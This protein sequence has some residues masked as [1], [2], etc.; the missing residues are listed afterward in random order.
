MTWLTW[1]QLRTRVWLGLAAL[2]ALA[3]TLAVTGPDLASLY[4][5]IPGP[6]CDA[7]CRASAGALV[8]RAR[9][10]AGWYG[11]L[12][13]VIDTV[14]LVLPV[15]VGIFWGAPLVARELETGTYQLVWNQSVTRTRWLATK[16]LG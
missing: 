4:D 15:L 14:L 16:L 10:S 12:S 2:A 1:R 8:G 11:V 13:E 9:D 3:I 7:A 6:D 5:S